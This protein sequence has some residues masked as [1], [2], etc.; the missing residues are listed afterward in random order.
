MPG[1][2]D[3]IGPVIGDQPARDLAPFGIMDRTV[4]PREK[5]PATVR[6]PAANSDLPDRSAP[7]APAS[8]VSLPGRFE[9]PGNPGLV[10]LYRVF[11]RLEEG[12]AFAALD[13]Q[14]RRHPSAR[15]D[16][17]GGA[18]RGRDLAG[19]EFCSHAAARQLRGRRARHRLDLRR[20]ALDDGMNAAFG[21]RAGGAVYRPSMSDRSTSRSAPIMVA[22]RAASRSLSP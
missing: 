10:A 19:V 15:C 9:L 17:H 12:R 14:Q 18:G 3:R 1:D 13:R 21:S 8:T 6:T 5:L 22:T 7:T 2:T 20:D 4:S 16:D 11:H